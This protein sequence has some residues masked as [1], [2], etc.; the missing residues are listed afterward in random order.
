[1]ENYKRI[2]SV[3]DLNDGEAKKIEIDD[4]AIALFRI[5]GEYFATDD[6]CT[7]EKASLSEGEIDNKTV[8]CPHHGARFN[9]KTGQAMT[10]P[11]MFPV[12]TYQIKIDGND[13][14]IDMKE[15]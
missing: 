11:A 3:N 4:K 9:I 14:M 2:A 1:M 6:T 5:D 8:T 12:K 13:I 15:V 7:H 10:L